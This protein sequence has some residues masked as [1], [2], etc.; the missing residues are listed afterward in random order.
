M[1][2]TQSINPLLK[3]TLW[4][5]LGIAAVLSVPFT[6]MQFSEEVDWSAGDFVIIGTLLF[7]LGMT[8][9]LIS[10]KVHD[11]GKRFL[12]GGALTALLLYV[13]AELAV[14]IFTNIGS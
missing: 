5:C 12:I 3:G 4:L 6:A 14:G 2:T 9:I 13:W 10:L 11:A 8:Y 1:K 7:A